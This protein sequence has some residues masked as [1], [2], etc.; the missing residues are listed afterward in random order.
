MV[1]GGFGLGSGVLLWLIL[2]KVSGEIRD[3]QY[4]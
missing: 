1:V 2:E 4:I 3:K